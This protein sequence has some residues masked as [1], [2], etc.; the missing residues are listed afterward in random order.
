M[1]WA[2]FLANGSHIFVVNYV[3]KQIWCIG[4]FLLQQD[5]VRGVYSK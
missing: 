1:M 2:L 4:E 3:Q 5:S